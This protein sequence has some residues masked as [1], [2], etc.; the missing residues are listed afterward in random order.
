MFERIGFAIERPELRGRRI[1][2][3]R[4]VQT[5]LLQLCDHVLMLRFQTREHLLAVF[6]YGF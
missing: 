1:G 3:L 2:A 4:V 5:A 6:E